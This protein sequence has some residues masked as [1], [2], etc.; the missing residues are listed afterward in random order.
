L[1][2]P[3]RILYPAKNLQEGGMVTPCLEERP[4][5]RDVLFCSFAN[6]PGQRNFFLSGDL[7]ETLVTIRRKADGRAE[8]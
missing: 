1:E 5:V 4:F 6:D 7:F 2:F 8:G 3:E